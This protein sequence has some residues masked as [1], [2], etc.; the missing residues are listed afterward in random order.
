MKY[1]R[2]LFILLI[3]MLFIFSCSG[4]EVTNLTGNAN[5]RVVG[6]IHGVV[7]NANTN[8]RLDSVKVT[9]VSKGHISSTYT[10]LEGYY[11]ITDLYAGDYEITYSKSGYAISRNYVNI[12]TVK[13]LGTLEEPSSNNYNLSLS[14]DENLFPLN[15]TLSGRIFAK[16]DNENTIAAAAVVVIA[17]FAGFDLSPDEYTALTDAQGNYSFNN[18]PSTATVVMRTLPFSSNGYDFQATTWNQGLAPGGVS[19]AGDKVVQIAPQTPILIQ[20][21]FLEGKFNLTDELTMTFSKEMDATTMQIDFWSNAI[22]NVDF[23]AGWS[24]NVTLTLTPHYPLSA[25]ATY[26][27]NLSGTSLDNNDFTFNGSFQTIDGMKIVSTNLERSHGLY[28]EFSVDSEIRITFDMEINLNVTGTFTSILDPSNN[29]VQTTVLLPDLKTIAIKPVNSL[30]N[31]TNYQIQFRIYS[32]IPGDHADHYDIS[33]PL[34]F[35]TVE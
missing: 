33:N 17:D 26:N 15:A 6:T 34:I 27:L 31:G 29:L 18:L 32:D 21:N 14:S 24:N 7:S 35:R 20:N 2:S 19:N 22:G 9:W 3:T 12:P 1:Y 10:D 30:N 13:Q 5:G 28:D 11:A 25:N 16:Q 23:N 4:D 8:V